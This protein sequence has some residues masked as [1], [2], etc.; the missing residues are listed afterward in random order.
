M[1]FL[2]LHLVARMFLLAVIVKSIVVIRRLNC[3][4]LIRLLWLVATWCLIG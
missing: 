4:E 1:L 2:L 3:V